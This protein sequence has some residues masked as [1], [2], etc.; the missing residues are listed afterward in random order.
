MVPA[1][2]DGNLSTLWL[3]EAEGSLWSQHPGLTVIKPLSIQ[4]PCWQLGTYRRPR[5]LPSWNPWSDGEALMP[6]SPPGSVERVGRVPCTM[7]E[8][9]WP[10]WEEGAWQGRK[11]GV[12]QL[13]PTQLHFE[14]PLCTGH[15]GQHE[16]LACAIPPAFS[17]RN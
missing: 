12:L 1:P 16:R 8:L 13:G 14:K 15:V 5:A 6:T 9:S 2:P 10:G 11:A 3:Q 17:I 7:T 4:G